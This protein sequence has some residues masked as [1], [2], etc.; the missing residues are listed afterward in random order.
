MP[1]DVPS[2]ASMSTCIEKIKAHEATLPQEPETESKG[3]ETTSSDAM[4]ITEEPS[5]LPVPSSVLP[6]VEVFLFNLCVTT[7]LR[8]GLVTEAAWGSSILVASIEGYNRRSL[9]FI[10]SKAL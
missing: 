4:D 5:K 7:L 2:F 8:Y 6:E 9:D 3:D 10:S 1:T